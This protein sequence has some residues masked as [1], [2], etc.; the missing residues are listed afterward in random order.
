M[1]LPKSRLVLMKPFSEGQVPRHNIN[2][3]IFVNVI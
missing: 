2:Q 1:G 3:D